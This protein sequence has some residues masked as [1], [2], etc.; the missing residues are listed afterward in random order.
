MFV[1]ENKVDC[2]M[3]FFLRTRLTLCVSMFISKLIVYT[4]MFCLFIRSKRYRLLGDIC[5][6]HTLTRLRITIFVVIY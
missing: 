4:N 1:L 5:Q 6:I 2:H 3:V